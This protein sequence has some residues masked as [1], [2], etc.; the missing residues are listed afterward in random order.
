MHTLQKGICSFVFVS[1]TFFKCNR[2][3]EHSIFTRS[4]E[5]TKKYPLH[6]AGVCLQF[7]CKRFSIW[8]MFDQKTRH[9]RKKHD[10]MASIHKYRNPVLF[11]SL[12]TFH[13]VHLFVICE[14]Q[15][16]LRTTYSVCLKVSFPQQVS[17]WHE[18]GIRQCGAVNL[19]CTGA[20]YIR[21]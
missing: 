5:S 15:G 4:L 14:R 18:E 6:A 8:S 10:C 2:E 16:F 1:R 21:G 7:P 17:R 9:V 12:L 13:N 19:F 20:G 11:K 3:R